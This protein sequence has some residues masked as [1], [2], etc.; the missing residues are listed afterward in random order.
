M[1]D[2]VSR[3]PHDPPRNGR[4]ANDASRKGVFPLI[5]LLFVAA[6]L[7][8]GWSLYNRHARQ[9]HPAPTPPASTPA[10]INSPPPKPP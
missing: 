4:L 10:P 3:K 5:W 7:A 6:L 9:A 2:P 8:F 1:S